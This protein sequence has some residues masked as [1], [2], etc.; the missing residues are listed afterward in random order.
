MDN[1][2]SRQRQV[3]ALQAA[4]PSFL[5]FLVV[6]MRFL[7][8]GTTALQKDIGSFLEF[9]PANLM[10]QAQRSQ[11]KTT[12]TAI[13]AVWYLIHN[14]QG[15]VLIVSAGNTTAN[16]ISTLIVR[17]IMHM[18]ILECL[19]PDKSAG[20]RVS[21]E[22]FDLHHSIK[23]VDKSPSVACVGITGTLQGKR[24]DL[25]I[26]DDVESKKNSMTAA[27]REI[28]VGLTR[29]FSSIVQDGRIIYLGT[30]QSQDSIYNT[31]PQR[32][33]TL[34]IWPGRYPTPEQIEHYGEHLAPY[35]VQ[36]LRLNPGLATGG[37][38]LGKDGQPTDPEL[39]PEEKL[40]A[41]EQDQ[42]SSHFQLQHMLCTKL[43][44]AERYPLR[45][46]SL[47]VMRLGDK[48][49]ATFERGITHEYRQLY[50]IGPSLRIQ[51]SSPMVVSSDLIKP[52]GRIMFID[53][54]GGGANGDETGWA[55][56]EGI[57]GAIFLRGA[58]GIAGG[59][60]MPR[61]I[62][63]CQIIQRFNP[64]RVIIEKNMGHGAFKNALLPI[65]RGPDFGFRGAVEDSAWVTGQKEARI[66][67]TL[68]PV[69]GR[70]SLV[71]D[72]EVLLE[73]W[74]S[75][76]YLPNERRQLHTLMFQLTKMTRQRGALIKDDRIDAVHAAVR[77]WIPLTGL[78]AQQAESQRRAAELAE[79]TKDPLGRQ[80]YTPN[81][82][83]RVARP[84]RRHR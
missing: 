1:L 71:V 55:V 4:F 58:G 45:A 28:L 36:R 2:N 51:V 9:G 37:G 25:L 18:P 72:E 82:A 14:P 69:M 38:L 22:A 49:P 44:D 31:L 23:G 39:L 62:K 83:N 57:P 29:E 76:A 78:D 24:A 12:L 8:F 33:F 5:P 63:L 46:E 30:P 73:D 41:K 64:D 35:I 26:A 74:E 16:E 50:Q 34:R 47:V 19:R 56:T 42:G 32:G 6:A 7:G 80:R 79:W 77:Y 21:V 40:L 52:L 59:S 48:L 67:D 75:T 54:A 61:L 66:C 53:P 70:G 11:A 81:L 84:T 65:L 10:V 43:S 60:D 20:D 13:F 3:A 17:L 68:E 15:R 27:Q